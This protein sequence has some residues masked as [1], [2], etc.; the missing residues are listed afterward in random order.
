MCRN[1]LRYCS[2]FKLVCPW[3]KCAL[4]AA[5]VALFD[6]RTLPPADSLLQETARAV[7]SAWVWNAH[8]FPRCS[9]L[10]LEAEMNVKLKSL[11]D[12]KK[13]PLQDSSIHCVSAVAALLQLWTW[14]KRSRIDCICKFPLLSNI[15][16]D[17]VPGVRG[18]IQNHQQF[19]G[20]KRKHHNVIMA[21]SNGAVWFFFFSRVLQ[22]SEHFPADSRGRCLLCFIFVQQGWK[23]SL[24]LC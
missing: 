9:L 21:W 24:E 12:N 19:P 4:D 1:M 2:G 16:S 8:L 10:V 20:N 18:S 11:I 13:K 22:H 7:A 3:L 5:R 14:N 6:V 23:M 15:Q 17:S